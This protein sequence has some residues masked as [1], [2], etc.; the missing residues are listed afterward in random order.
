MATNITSDILRRMIKEREIPLK[1]LAKM[2]PNKFNDHRDYYPLASLVKNG[3]IDMYLIDTDTDKG[4]ETEREIM[5][6]I[7]FYTMSLAKTQVEYAGITFTQTKTMENEKFYCTAKTDLYFLEQKQLRS[8][9]LVT[10]SVGILIGVV[11]AFFGAYFQS[12]IK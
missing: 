8:D 9:R 10:I 3:Y 11:S 6:A 12:M 2:L 4:I 7:R 5:L 1:E